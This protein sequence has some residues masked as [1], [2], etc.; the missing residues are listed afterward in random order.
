LTI[1]VKFEV[2]DI[3]TLVI[4]QKVSHSYTCE[5]D[6]VNKQNQ[7]SELFQELLPFLGFLLFC[8]PQSLDC[9][10]VDHGI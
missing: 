6:D 2:N 10:V 3:P 5:T 9:F 7:N 8:V 1:G 4:I